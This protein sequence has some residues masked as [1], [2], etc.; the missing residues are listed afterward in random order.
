M[1]NEIEGMFHGIPGTFTCAADWMLCNVSDGDGHAQ[2]A[3][4]RIVGPS[5]RLS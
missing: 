1:E 3:H 2:H 5:R 4:R